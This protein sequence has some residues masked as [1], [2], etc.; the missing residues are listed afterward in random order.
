MAPLRRLGLALKDDWGMPEGRSAAFTGAPTLDQPMS[1]TS[2]PND[3]DG[4]KIADDG[5]L[6]RITAFHSK[7]LGF[8]HAQ[9]ASSMPRSAFDTAAALPA[10]CVMSRHLNS[11]N[12]S[13]PARPAAFLINI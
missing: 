2:A 7:M 6:I 4:A 12:I 3:V 10:R 11:S 5:V 13:A 8:R 1:V 9:T